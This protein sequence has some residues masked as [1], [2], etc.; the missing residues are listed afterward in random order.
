MDEIWAAENAGAL[1]SLVTYQE[2]LNLK[3]L[4]VATP[5][6]GPST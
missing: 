4:W 6:P 2:G 3:Y 1:S 5:T